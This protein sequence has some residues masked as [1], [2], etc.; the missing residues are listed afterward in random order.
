MN[1]EE[2]LNQLRNDIYCRIKPSQ[3][4][5][6][7][8]FAI[9]DIPAGIDPFVGTVQ[10]EHIFITAE[11]MVGAHPNVRRLVQDMFVY[12]NNSYRLPANGLAQVD[13]AYY[14]NHSD[15]PNIKAINDDR[16]FETIRI[17]KEGEELFSDYSTYN[18]KEDVFDR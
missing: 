13:I 7:G 8:V 6:V 1:K 10:P 15:H 9:R 14:T 5:G 3:S 18:D 12:R 2:I 4:G 16:T 11:E 17:I